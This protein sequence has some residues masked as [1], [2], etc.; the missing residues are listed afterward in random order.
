MCLH[1]IQNKM[2]PLSNKVTSKGHNLLH[3]IEGRNKYR[4]SLFHHKSTSPHGCTSS[5]LV[6]GWVVAYLKP[7][8]PKKSHRRSKLSKE[9]F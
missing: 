8:E 2:I 4:Y 7:S 1:N 6:K 9:N 5:K 3:E